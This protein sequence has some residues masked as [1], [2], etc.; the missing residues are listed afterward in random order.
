MPQFGGSATASAAAV[1]TA[2]SIAL[3]PLPSTRAPASAAAWCAA[4]TRPSAAAFIDCASF[5]DIEFLL[6]LVQ[7]GVVDVLVHPAVHVLAELG[8]DL[9]GVG[10]GLDDDARGRHEIGRASCRE[11]V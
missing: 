5:L 11:R 3:P 6:G 2:A 10:D 7:V 4:T 9:A 8:G 1:A